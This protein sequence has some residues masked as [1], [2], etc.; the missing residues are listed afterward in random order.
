MQVS[1]VGRS[2]KAKHCPCKHGTRSTY[3]QIR[4][5][6]GWCARAFKVS[7]RWPQRT[8]IRDTRG[9]RALALL[10]R[11]PP[12]ER[13]DA[14]LPYSNPFMQS[15]QCLLTRQLL[16]QRAH[17]TLDTERVLNCLHGLNSRST[18]S[19]VAYCSRLRKKEAW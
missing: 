5:V 4:A 13:C 2:K 16:L 19:S 12:A 3:L 10:W 18:R 8:F 15:A 7:E 14:C 9:R 1:A 17:S 6:G 11:W